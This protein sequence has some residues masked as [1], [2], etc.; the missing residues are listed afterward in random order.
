MI[1]TVLHVL[2][3]R[4]LLTGSGITLDAFARRAKQKG[5][6]QHVAVGVPSN[7]RNPVVGGLVRERIHP[8]LFGEGDLDFPVPGMSDVMPYPST[9]FSS[10][11]CDQLAAYENEWRDHLSGVI[12]TVRPDII[13]SHH[14][15]LSVPCSEKWHRIR[16]L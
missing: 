8:L 14:V 9:R 6:E 15:W 13:H 5:W 16:P 7:E 11:T 2:S 3:Q 4:P 1:N 10:M 12:A